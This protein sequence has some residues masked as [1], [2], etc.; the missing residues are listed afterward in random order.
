[1]IEHVY[2]HVHVIAAQNESDHEPLSSGER[3][4]CVC[5][6]G[7]GRSGWSVIGSLMLWG[8]LSADVFASGATG[9]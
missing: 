6:V 9:E 3:S 7:K 8:I 1:M 4:L 5:E 2:V